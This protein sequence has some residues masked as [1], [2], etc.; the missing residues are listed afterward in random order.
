[1]AGFARSD[2]DNLDVTTSDLKTAYGETMIAEITPIV[3][4]DFNYNINSEIFMTSSLSGTLTTVSGNLVMQ[5]SASSGSYAQLRSRKFIKLRTGQ[6]NAVR[7]S[8][9]FMTGATTSTQIYGIGDDE[10]GYFVGMSGSQ[11]GVM[12]RN[13]GIDYWTLQNQFSTDTLDGQGESRM[14]LDPTKGNVYEIQ[15]QWLGYG[16]IHFNIENQNSSLLTEFHRIDYGNQNTIPS[17][18]F[19]SNPMWAKVTNYG[20]GSSPQIKTASMLGYVE[21]QLVYS[22]P[23]FAKSHTK[24]VAANTKTSVLT[25]KSLTTYEGFN[26]KIPSKVLFISIACEGNKPTVFEITKN[27]TLGGTPSYTNVHTNNSVMQFDTAG[28]TVTGGSLVTI[29]SLGK[30]SSF[31]ID[32]ETLNL[33]IQPTDTLTISA[34]ST[35]DTDATAC[36][37][38]VED[39]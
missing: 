37:T 21:G 3:Q 27:A 10:N 11:F 18:R 8:A 24:T 1:M 14:I 26:N 32:A 15:Y 39:H 16:A 35:L 30:S 19:G 4:T 12:R 9:M 34:L 17:T 38:W 20:T 31:T 29:F 22:G 6:G 25:L 36:F 13:N 7:F 5:C 28:T 33:F 23:R 2:F